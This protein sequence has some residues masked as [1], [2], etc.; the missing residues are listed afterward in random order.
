MSLWWSNYR[1]D[2]LSNSAESKQFR[3]LQGWVSNL[4]IKSSQ[5]I[6]CM[7]ARR[8]NVWT[9]TID[10]PA[11]F[12]FWRIFRRAALLLRAPIWNLKSIMVNMKQRTY[13]R[14]E[15]AGQWGW[16]YRVSVA[17]WLGGRPIWQTTL[18]DRDSDKMST[19]ITNLESLSTPENS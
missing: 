12:F 1:I 19:A 4:Q 15:T 6:Y 18:A 14:K 17:I 7:R 3:N 2:L 11:R 8:C 16:P 5:K 13:G 10:K 9:P